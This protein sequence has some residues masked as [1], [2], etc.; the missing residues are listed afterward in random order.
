M[1]D[2]GQLIK[3]L[4]NDLRSIPSTG[5]CAESV[6]VSRPIAASSGDNKKEDTASVVGVVEESNKKGK[7]FWSNRWVRKYVLLFVRHGMLS[8]EILVFFLILLSVLKPS[9]L[10]RQVKVKEGNEMVRTR[11]SVM[12]LFV[13]SISFTAM[14]HVMM[15]IQKKVFVHL[16]ANYY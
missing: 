4:R 12:L 1:T 11:F 16:S 9:F 6:V 2:F 7:T 3:N 13:Y 8:T 14:I 5:E 10:Y 15:H